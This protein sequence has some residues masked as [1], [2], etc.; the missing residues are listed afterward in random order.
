MGFENEESG[1]T[2]AEKTRYCEFIKTVKKGSEPVGC[3]IDIITLK[4]GGFLVVSEDSTVFYQD[5]A[6]FEEQKP[7][8]QSISI[9]PLLSLSNGE[10]FHFVE[11]IE[12]WN[13]GGYVMVDKVK[14]ANNSF[15][16]ISDELVCFYLNEDDFYNGDYESGNMIDIS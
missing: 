10:V 6:D 13:T 12:T 3:L 14:F 16:A 9:D 15:L 5:L 1:G 2:E 7:D 11:K 8:Y 4:Q